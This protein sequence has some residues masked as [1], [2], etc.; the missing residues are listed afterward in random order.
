MSSC[1]SGRTLLSDRTSIGQAGK[2]SA[3]PNGISQHN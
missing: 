2:A 3:V 1:G